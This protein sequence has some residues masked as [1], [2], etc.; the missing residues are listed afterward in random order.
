MASGTKYL[1]ENGLQQYHQGVVNALNKKA[2]ITDGI[3]YVEGNSTEVGVWT[4]E[5]NDIAEYYY[6]LCVLYKIN[7]E[8]SSATTLN[9]N[10]LGA[11]NIYRSGIIGLTTEY[12]VN[13]VVLLTY[14]P[15]PNK[16]SGDCWT[17]SGDNYQ[18]IDESEAITAEEIDQI[19]NLT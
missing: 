5:S 4:G 14:T 8:G 9:I 17:V 18:D 15:G 12:P 1:D 2:N 13:S 19:L 3:F 10:G 11:K 6:G 7:V 16:L